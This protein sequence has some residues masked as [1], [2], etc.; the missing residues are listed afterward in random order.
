MSFYKHLQELRV[1]FIVSFFV[2]CLVG[3]FCYVYSE[4][5]YKI[6]LNPLYKTNKVER[7]IYTNLTDAFFTYIKVAF[8]SAS[9]IVFPFFL[10]QIYSFIAP[11]LYKSEKKVLS[12]Y[13]ILSPTLFIMGAILAYY[14]IMPL[15]WQFLVSFESPDNKI[16]LLPKIDEYLSLTMSLIFGFGVSFQL[17]LFLSLLA[18]AGVIDDAWLRKKRR[19]AIIIIFAA[20]AVLTPPDILS[21]IYLAIP[22]I[23]LYEIS[24]LLC[25]YQKKDKDSKK[26]QNIF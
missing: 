15:A 7:M 11:G 10:W 3:A 23:V 25:V 2:F 12:F 4:N 19:L 21:Q 16:V 9:C 18:R 17:P 26:I 14:N 20:A 6:L 22:L 5:I 1:R 8:F 24:I 13:F